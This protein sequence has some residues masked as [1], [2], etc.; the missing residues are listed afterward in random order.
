MNLVHA[1]GKQ[2]IYQRA[3]ELRRT[4][5]LYDLAHPAL[6]EVFTGSVDRFADIALRLRGCRK[7]LDVGSG[8]G[9]LLTLLNELGHEC[10]A[11][12]F[13]DQTTRYPHAYAGRPLSFQVCNVE[14]DSLPFDDGSFDAV[15]C[16]QVLEHF[17]HSH[18]PL[19]QE[20]RRVLRPGGVVEVDVPNAVSYRNRSRMLR[21]KHITNDYESHFLRA[22]PVLYKGMSFYP[23]RHNREFTAAELHLLLQIAGFRNIQVSFLKGRRHREGMR[24]LLSIGSILRD[25]IPSLR[26]FLIAFAEK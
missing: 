10:H 17:T 18:L 2:A 19:M 9:M 21:G 5:Y 3:L 13:I 22:E 11:V 20:I 7:V 25:A 14:V 1:L 15:T 23:V 4:G 26:K 24:G 12:D 6:E 16:C 8:H